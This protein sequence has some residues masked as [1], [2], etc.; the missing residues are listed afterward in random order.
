MG[1]DVSRGLGGGGG[2]RLTDP[3]RTEPATNGSAASLTTSALSPFWR[4]FP[5]SEPPAGLLCR[6]PRLTKP[7]G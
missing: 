7:R 5:V 6:R 4:H 3:R 2:P 1:L